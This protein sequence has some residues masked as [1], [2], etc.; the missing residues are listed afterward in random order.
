GRIEDAA[1]SPDGLTVFIARQR[2]RES[3][4][5]VAMY[6]DDG[7]VLGSFGILGPRAYR[8]ALATA[9]GLLAYGA[10]GTPEVG[11]RDMAAGAARW[12]ARLADSVEALTFA[13]DHLWA[14]TGA[15]VVA[16]DLA[17]GA[18][19]PYAPGPCAPIERV[20]VAADHVFA[21]ADE[22]AITIVDLGENRL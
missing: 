11:L 13:G 22:H 3:T 19:I 1:L 12:S 8:V 21:K 10:R 17:S 9:D 5:E 4:F 20:V 18:E 6:G 7:R 15:G 2:P 16:L 14:A